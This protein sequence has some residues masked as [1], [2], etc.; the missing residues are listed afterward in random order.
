MLLSLAW[1]NVWRNHKRSMIIVLSIAFG[2][3]G[4]LFSD[5]IML[6]M[7]DSVV[8][9]AIKRD[10]AHIQIHKVDYSKEKNINNYIPD[11]EKVLL[12]CKEIPGVAAV[13]AR[14]L[15]E[16]MAASPSSSFGVRIIGIDPDAARRVTNMYSSVQEG[17][18]FESD[19]RN[20][21]VIGK[22][23]AERLNLKIH[24]K[25]I[26]SFQD[27][28]GNI[29]YIA[30]RVSGIFKTSSSQ[31]DGMNVYL[32]QKDIFRILDSPPIFHEIALRVE[33][34]Q[35]F[36]SIARKLKERFALLDV[37]DWQEIAPELAYLS[38][39]TITYSYVF[40]AIILLALLF[41]ITNTMLMSV[42]DRIREFG[43]LIAI[44]MKKTRVFI[45]IILETIFL[46][47][48]GGLLG[49]LLGVASISVFA[50]TGIDLSAIAY[51]LESFGASTMLYPYLPVAMYVILTVMIII[52]ANIAA[53]FPA[54]KATHLVPSEA[55]RS[56]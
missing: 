10:L 44:G 27:L 37:K 40:V 48:T 41:G 32:R 55:I 42:V 33:S 36:K 20:P 52:A 34:P 11:G 23:L 7:M 19:K 24:S 22:K 18:Y 46:S 53:L 14:T 43:V 25:V 38:D 6:G 8:E 49:I 51:S 28:Q 3:W 9:T 1:R 16:G 31:F 17:S 26:L 47:L 5:A 13:S 2:L 30:C 15:I 39:M 35:Q 29:T 45:M 4:G 54:W 21:I 50:H 56:Y 12:Q